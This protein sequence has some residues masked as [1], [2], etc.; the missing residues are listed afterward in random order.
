MLSKVAIV[1]I[2][3]TVKP[4]NVVS[5]LFIYLLLFYLLDESVTIN[6]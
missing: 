2:L 6:I 3:P 4:T 5:I 1:Y